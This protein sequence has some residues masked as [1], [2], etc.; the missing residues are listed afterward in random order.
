[1]WKRLK[2]K[3][4]ATKIQLQSNFIRKSYYEDS[5]QDYVENHDEVF[6]HLSTIY[7]EVSSF[8]EVAMLLASFGDKKMSTVIHVFAWLHTRKKS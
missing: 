6:N 3:Y 4:A 7:C 1:M 2:D 8:M 5:I